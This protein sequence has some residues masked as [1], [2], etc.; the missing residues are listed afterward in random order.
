MRYDETRARSSHGAAPA[1]APQGTRRHALAVTAA[2]LVLWTSS[3]SAYPRGLSSAPLSR[4]RFGLS[5]DTPPIRGPNIENIVPW[6]TTYFNSSDDFSLLT[7][8]TILIN[9]AGLYHF[10]LSVDWPGQH[11]VDHDLRMTSI[12]RQRPAGEASTTKGRDRIASADI[13]GSDAPAVLRYEERWKPGLVK[14]ASTITHDIRISPAGF[15]K[16]GDIAMLSL[17]QIGDDTIGALAAKSLMV[18]A[19]VVGPDMVRLFLTNTASGFNIQIPEGTLKLL[20]MSASQSRG[21]SADAYHVLHSPSEDI[22]KGELIYAVVKS[23]AVGD[24]LQG[25]ATTYLQIDRLA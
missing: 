17:S 6:D 4:G 8:G 3:M 10:V 18:Q 2:G 19:R 14:A 11:G 12:R 22:A 9:K 1:R 20:V 5:S 16:L 23:R 13:P 24:Y 15:V 7:D 21:E 25:T